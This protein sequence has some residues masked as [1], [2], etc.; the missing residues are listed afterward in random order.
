MTNR[1]N[2]ASRPILGTQRRRSGTGQRF[3]NEIR[4]TMVKVADTLSVPSVN[5]L[6]VK[7]YVP[8]RYRQG[9]LKTECDD[10]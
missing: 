7:Y 3:S 9:S 1:S 6:K 2:L 4:S 10:G 5:P 8:L